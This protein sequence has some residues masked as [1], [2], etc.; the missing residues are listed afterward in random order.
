MQKNTA[1]NQEMQ[2]VQISELTKHKGQKNQV[3]DT[4]SSTKKVLQQYF[5]TQ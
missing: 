2:E 3:A 4:E 5:P 1:I